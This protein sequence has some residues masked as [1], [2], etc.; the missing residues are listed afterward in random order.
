MTQAIDRLWNVWFFCYADVIA[1]Q[2]MRMSSLRKKITSSDSHLLSQGLFFVSLGLF[3]IAFW[4]VGRCTGAVTSTPVESSR[5]LRETGFNENQQKMYHNKKALKWF[6]KRQNKNR[7]STSLFEN[8][9]GLAGLLTLPLDVT[10]RPCYFSTSWGIPLVFLQHSA[11]D[12]LASIVVWRK[13]R[14]SLGTPC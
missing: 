1:G 5:A 9:L 8:P 11:S 4:T 10:C 12:W 3:M 2:G 7:V 14:C 13:P 6:A